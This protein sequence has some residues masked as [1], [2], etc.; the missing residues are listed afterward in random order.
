MQVHQLHYL[1]F[2][3]TCAHWSYALFYML[4]SATFYAADVVLRLHSTYTCAAATARV[5][6]KDGGMMTL[7]LP[8]PDSAADATRIA[9]QGCP[10]LQGL[11]SRATLPARGSGGRHRRVGRAQLCARPVG[12]DDL[13]PAHAWP[14][15]NER[16]GRVV[17]PLHRRWLRRA[18][19]CGRRART[20]RPHRAG[21]P[22]DAP[23]APCRENWWRRGHSRG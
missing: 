20:P 17:A 7:L 11:S 15:A 16:H 1:F 2:G 6:G 8:V 12:G 13:L 18:P 4:P 5:H 14:V 10:Y 23:P 19:Q 22:L 9:A 21:A 3:F